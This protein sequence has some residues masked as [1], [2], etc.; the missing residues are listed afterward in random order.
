MKSNRYICN[1]T[2]YP[3]DSALTKRFVVNTR[4]RFVYVLP[5]ILHGDFVYEIKYLVNP[6]LNILHI[7]T[8]VDTEM[9]CPK[10]KCGCH[11][12]ILLTLRKKKVHGHGGPGFFLIKYRVSVF[13]EFQYNNYNSF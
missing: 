11:Y 12:F 8:S 4:V 9:C 7:L 2:S 6:Q 13:F 10:G 1:E 5:H 3:H